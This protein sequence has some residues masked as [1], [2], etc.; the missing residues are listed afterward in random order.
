MN[1]AAFTGKLVRLAFLDLEKDLAEWAKWD[2][3]SEYQQLLDWGPANLYHTKQVREW[4]EK[5]I[6]RMYLFS[7]HTLA[8]DKIIGS[9]DLGGINWTARD[10]WLGVGIGERD[11]W[12]KGYGS[13]AINILLQFAFQELNLNRV[14]LNVFEYNERAIHAY[15]KIGFQHE[16]RQRQV[17]NRFDRRWDLIYMGILRSEWETL[18]L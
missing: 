4:V 17:L 7:I 14:T 18:H 3:D 8:D 11:Y 5:E 16:G 10:A 2:R 13:D 15:E 6:E 1:A 12:G 9:L